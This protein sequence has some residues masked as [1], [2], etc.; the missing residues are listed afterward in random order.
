MKKPIL[1]VMA[2]GIGSRYGGL[3][4]TEPVGTSGELIIDYSVFDA[5]KAGFQRVLFIINRSI[6]KDFKEIIGHR[7]E[8]VIEVN[9]AY[10]ELTDVPESILLD[11]SRVKPLGTAHAIYAARN[12]IDAPFAVINADDYYGADA[13]TI[14]YDYLS[15]SSLGQYEYAMVGYPLSNTVTKNGSV[16]RG[17]CTLDDNHFLKEIVE[18]THIK[19]LSDGIAYMDKTKKWHPLNPE[20]NVS[21]NMWGFAPSLVSEIT[22]TL[23]NY[24]KEVLIDNPLKCE[25][26]LPYVVDHMIHLNSCSV[27]VLK[28]NEKW[29]GVT[30]SNDKSIVVEALF[31]MVASG[32]YPYRLW[33]D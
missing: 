15:Q 7:L 4:Q 27:K 11:K 21:M 23:T 8:L 3:K 33:E 5:I 9:Y 19:T 14:I 24:L 25:Y 28:T 26:F 2:A 30:Y 22:S 17:I 16:S 18:R 31:Q 12:L 32:K 1:V 29:Y 20:T 13:F 10:Q 6:E